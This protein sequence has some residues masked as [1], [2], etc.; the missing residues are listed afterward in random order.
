M[1]C[2]TFLID[3]RNVTHSSNKFWRLLITRLVK[4]N[5]S[6][7]VYMPLDT[8]KENKNKHHYLWEVVTD[9]LITG[10]VVVSICI[11]IKAYQ[12]RDSMASTTTPHHEWRHMPEVKVSLHKPEFKIECLT[13]CC[14]IHIVLFNGFRRKHIFLYL[15]ASYI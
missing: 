3:I 10:D 11:L 8:V 4:A 14:G 9:W 7:L 15:V 13:A 12:W 6:S 1:F 5:V 2:L